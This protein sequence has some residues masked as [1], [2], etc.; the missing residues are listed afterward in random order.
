MVYGALIAMFSK[1]SE[2]LSQP[3]N[4]TNEEEPNKVPQSPNEVPQAPSSG[5][6][7]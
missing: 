3:G 7:F 4:V 1:F 2:E 6:P 5:I